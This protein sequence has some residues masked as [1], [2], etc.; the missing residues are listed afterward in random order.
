LTVPVA[1]VV[2]CRSSA[3]PDATDALTLQVL[4]EIRVDAAA[5]AADRTAVIRTAADRLLAVLAEARIP[6]EVVRRYDTIPWL[7]LRIAPASR[8]RLA[9]LPEVAAVRE[10]RVEHPLPKGNP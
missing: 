10:D 8:E 6:H 1:L 9:A 7:A 5:A 3:A 4:V 2:A